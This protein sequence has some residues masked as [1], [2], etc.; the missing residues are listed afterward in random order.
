VARSSVMFA[1]ALLA[2]VSA[3]SSTSLAQVAAPLTE[4][5]ALVR[6]LPGSAQIKSEPL[7][8]RLIVKLRDPSAAELARPLGASRIQALSKSAQ[9]E[10]RPVRAMALGASVVALDTPLRLSAAREVAAR[11]ARD[12]A[13]EYAVPD[14]ILKKALFPN[15][16]RFNEWQWNLFAPTTT[17][18]GSVGGA[19]NKQATAVGGANLPSAWDVTT[20]SPSVVVAVIDT[21]IVN[22]NDLNGIANSDIYVPSG[23]W[24]AGY[25]FISSDIGAGSGVPAN[26][27]ANDGN[28]RDSDPSDP[29]D[30]VTGSE[31]TQ[32]PET[33][34]DGT[35][36]TTSSSWHG[37]HTAGV[38][39][40]TA[41][42]AIGIVG[43]GW[44]VRILPVRALGKCGGSLSDV[45]DAIHWSAG[46]PVP[47]VPANP[48]PARVINLSLGGDGACSAPL[49]AAVT[50]A[51]GAGS[52]VVAATGNS[53][54]LTIG[55]PANC[56]GAIAVTAHT[57]N[58]ENA[59]YADIGA[60]TTISAP[61]GG[62]PITLGTNGPTDDPNWS[63][64]YIWSAVLFGT[65]TPTSLDSQ[66]RSGSA[67]G[68]FTGTS[69]AAPHVAGIAALI[70]SALPAAT[71]AQVRELIVNNA[72]PYPTG[73]ACASGGAFAGQCGA[74]LLDATAAL[75]A[76]VGS[77]PPTAPVI[78]SAPQSVTVTVGETATFS[79]SASGTAPL[80]YQ[81]LRDGT[82]IA[83]ATSATY[84]TPALTL[85]DSGSRFAV[86]VS[87]SSGS[88][89]SAEAVATVT[90]STGVGTGSPA[91]PPTGGGGGGGGS[92][93]WPQL[94]LL[95][96][97]TAVRIGRRDR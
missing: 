63:G 95:L 29:G 76:A 48:T 40:A 26:L 96:A 71:P 90:E 67:Y 60:A 97:L 4:K 25:D 18:M 7:V 2:G 35:A 28:G 47:G 81:W 66:G 42:N 46:L 51:I 34:D 36:G 11:L 10:L 31:K 85:S 78:A 20:G 43:I 1:A 83:G 16:P 38:V 89:T 23:R 30:W 45:A 72:R 69:A 87:N 55:Q 15:E 24:L 93:P 32:Y 41:N 33:C 17:Y 5:Q 79:V 53:G 92:L 52:V 74:G 91:A 6:G 59:D 88:V 80:S 58:G 56:A 49:Q 44:Q 77:P 84:T 65:T 37:A 62:K 61:G 64:Y 54:S 13:V 14:I 21:G 39:A 94:L 68:G 86:T 50:A 75:L 70:K 9:S 19:G 82:A 27:V 22:H 12:P 3:L 57:I 8:G 73:S